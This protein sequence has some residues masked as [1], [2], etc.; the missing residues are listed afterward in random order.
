MFF[1]GKNV[2][3]IRVKT[4]LNQIMMTHEYYSIQD[5]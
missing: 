4:S 2:G 5:K 1:I 3:L